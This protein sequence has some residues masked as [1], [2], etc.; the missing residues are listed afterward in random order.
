MLGEAAAGIKVFLDA[1]ERLTGYIL[2]RNNKSGR[3]QII[4]FC[5]LMDSLHAQCG[6]LI[7]RVKFLEENRKNWHES[8][9]EGIRR[10]L[11]SIVETHHEVAQYFYADEWEDENHDEHSIMQTLGLYVERLRQSGY[12]AVDGSMRFF[13][14]SGLRRSVKETKIPDIFR[15]ADFETFIDAYE[16]NEEAV[17]NLREY[18]AKNFDVL[19]VMA[20]SR[21]LATAKKTPYYLK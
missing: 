12:Y 13:S 15:E 18:V 20:V 11:K 10:Q 9:V 3:Q 19:E 6:Q 16:T 17:V 2:Q 4:Y 14:N 7:S 21:N 1:F 5:I 8:D